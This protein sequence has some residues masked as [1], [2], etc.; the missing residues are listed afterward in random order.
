MLEH[1]VKQFSSDKILKHLDRVNEW[2]AG[3]NP[4]P[5]TVEMDMT[6]VCS[7]KCPECVVN[8]FRED[9]ADRLPRA[10]AERIITELAEGG[11]RGLIFTGGGDPLC[12]RD[13]PD[14]MALAASKGIDVAL[15]TNGSLLTEPIMEVALRHCMWIR[16]S[17]DCITPATFKLMHGLPEEDFRKVIANI[18]TLAAMKR[19]LGSRAT[20]GVGFLTC[21]ATENEMVEA[22]RQAKDWGVDYLQYRPLQ[23]HRGGKFEYDWFEVEDLINQAVQYSGDGYEVLYSKHKYESIKRQDYGRDYPECLGHQFASTIA[24]DGKVYICCHTRGYEKYCLGNL[25]EHSFH[26]IWNGEE[27]RKAI[28][29][30]DFKDCIPLCRDNTFN[31]IL[32]KIKQP[33]EHENFL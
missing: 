23:I 26:E 16:V 6:N 15:I 30:I 32:W 2:L 14:M 12:H 20:V 21:A 31:Q 27:R 3:G 33:R 5:I 1:D 17:L 10:L 13:T 28:G 11:V 19:H 22:A 18:K 9:N 8:Y 7:H 24:A 25:H 4:F 29:R